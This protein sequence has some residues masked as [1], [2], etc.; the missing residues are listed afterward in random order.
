LHYLYDHHRTSSIHSREGRGR[1]KK[2]TSSSGGGGQTA[3]GRG[4]K[5]SCVEETSQA[6]SSSSPVLEVS[7]AHYGEDACLKTKKNKNKKKRTKEGKIEKD[8]D[9]SS[10]EKQLEILRSERASLVCEYESSDKQLDYAKDNGI[11]KAKLEKLTR[12]HMALQAK[13]KEL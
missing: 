11:L 8:E 7:E 2:R 3:P 13:H 6:P 1:K 9:S 5:Y 4:S 12:E 10:I